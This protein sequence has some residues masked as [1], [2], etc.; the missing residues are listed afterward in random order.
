MH[1]CLEYI[2]LGKQCD[3]RSKTKVVPLQD[4]YHFNNLN[5]SPKFIFENLESWNY[6]GSSTGQAKG[7]ESEVCIIPRAV[8]N[9]PFRG[10]L[11]KLILCDTYTPGGEPHES[12]T[13]A[14]A[15]ANF[16]VRPDTKPW[17]GL[18]QE[19][20]LMKRFDSGVVRSIGF[21]E[22]GQAISG[23]PQGQYY[24]SVGANNAYGRKIVEQ[25]LKCCLNAGV[26]ISGIKK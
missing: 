21:N 23:N 5:E 26:K 19:Y 25:H 1:I 2:W 6:D 12:N 8:F 11:H 16:S 15:V 14:K 20:L 10:D 22:N 17:Y 24:C 9:D 18:E 4:V 3:L 7:K 13:R